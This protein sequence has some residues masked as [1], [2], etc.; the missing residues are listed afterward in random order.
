MVPVGSGNKPQWNF[1]NFKTYVL[2]RPNSPLRWAA[3]KHTKRRARVRLD[4]DLEGSWR[5]AE[6]SQTFHLL[7][8]RI[9]IREPVKEALFGSH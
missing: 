2:A 1:R 8:V 6:R 4:V 5:K 7:D 3:E 9:G